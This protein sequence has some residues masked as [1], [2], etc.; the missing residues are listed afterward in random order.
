[1]SGNDYVKYMTQQIVRYMDTPKPER[2]KIKQE[3]KEEPII[4]SSKWFGV[5]PFAF[6]LL[7]KKRK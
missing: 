1:M 4:Y 3:K 6:R 7:L 2:K 5:L